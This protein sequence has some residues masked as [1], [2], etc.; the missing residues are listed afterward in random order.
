MSG[1]ARARFS[2]TLCVTL[3]YHCLLK[4][5]YCLPIHHCPPSP[6]F[7]PQAGIQLK[8]V[9]R[10]SRTPLK[11]CEFRFNMRH[12]NRQQYLLK[13]IRNRPLKVS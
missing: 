6:S 3:I 8:Y 12:E 5:T 4:R 11:E 1:Y 13:S 10:R 9:V 7:S 2:V